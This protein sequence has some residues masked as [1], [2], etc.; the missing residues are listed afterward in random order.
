MSIPR[1]TPSFSHTIIH[2]SGQFR[3]N[4]ISQSKASGRWPPPALGIPIRASAVSGARIHESDLQMPDQQR[5]HRIPEAAYVS[6]YP[7][8]QY[9]ASMGPPPPTL[10]SPPGFTRGSVVPAAHPEESAVPEAHYQGNKASEKS[11]RRGI[12]TRILSFLG[13]SWLGYGDRK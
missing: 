8:A 13:L 1:E 11:G 2:Y 4:L 10:S 5:P 6:M 7:Q 9:R 3:L 12:A